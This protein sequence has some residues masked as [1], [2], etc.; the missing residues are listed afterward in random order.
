M[1]DRAPDWA[2]HAPLGEARWR[3]VRITRRGVSMTLAAAAFWAAMAAVSAFAGLDAG[4]L[5]LFFVCGGVLVY[6]GGY[7]LNRL[8]GGD[9]TAR[10]SEFRGLVAAMTAGQVLGWPMVVFLLLRDTALLAFA[11]AAMLGAHFLP[12]GWLYRAPA[13]L[14]LGVGSV[15][16]AGLL[17]AGSPATANTTIAATMAAAYLAAGVAVL[18]RNRRESVSC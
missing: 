15:L 14:A 4:A 11:L 7:V 17:Q 16:V 6:P 12:Y 5:A 18:A 2:R 13:Y 1:P 10:G 8:L 3:L 9:L